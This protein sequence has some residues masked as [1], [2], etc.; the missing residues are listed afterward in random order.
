M[1]KSTGRIF[2]GILFICLPYVVSLAGED[3]SSF[4][5]KIQEVTSPQGLKAWLVEDH[6]LPLLSMKFSFEA[7]SIYEPLGKEGLSTLVSDMLTEGAGDLDHKAFSEALQDHAIHID[8]ASQNDV[9]TGVIRTTTQNRDKAF[10]LLKMALEKPLF[11]EKEFEKVKHSYVANLLNLYKNPGFLAEK[12]IIETVYAGHSYARLGVGSEKSIANIKRDDLEKFRKENFVK[13]G[14]VMAVCGD[15]TPQQLGVLLDRV[16][17]SLP[18][19]KKNPVSIPVALLSNKGALK[20]VKTSHP[21]SMVNFMQEGLSF[22]DPN[23]AKLKIINTILGG[24]FSSRLMK[25]IRVK[26]GLVYG[27]S[28]G[29]NELKYSATLSGSF[30]SDNSKAKEAITLIKEQWKALKEKGIT[31]KELEDAKSHLLGSFALNFS[32]SL[33]IVATLF[34]LQFL[35]ADVDYVNRRSALINK[36]TLQDVNEFAQN[37][38]KPDQLTFAIAGNPEGLQSSVPRSQ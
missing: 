23:H 18:E 28:T 12:E 30:A 6:T 16:F 15:I 13:Q 29:L 26:R 2:L 25:E 32:S 3:S 19:K 31:E 7:G 8:F 36:C 14:M 27:I 33:G 37:F 17:G 20:I 11:K 4:H 38:L 5:I 1:I 22:K 9:F 24:D 34:H 10:H 21:Q 35:G